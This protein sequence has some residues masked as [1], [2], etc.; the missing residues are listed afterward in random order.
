MA[1]NWGHCT[2]MCSHV[3]CMNLSHANTVQLKTTTLGGFRIVLAGGGREVWLWG[4]PSA[5]MWIPGL[6]VQLG[7]QTVKGPFSM[8][9]PEVFHSS[10][11]FTDDF[12]VSKS[13]PSLVLKGYLT[14]PSQEG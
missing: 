1:D 2:H 9:C 8:L 11:L 4:L 13:P 6:L 3:L 5:L 14:S 7:P 10:E 12:T